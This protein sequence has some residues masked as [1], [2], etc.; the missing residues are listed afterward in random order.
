M[1]SFSVILFAAAAASVRVSM[2]QW[3][4]W[5]NFS[6]VRGSPGLRVSDMFVCLSLLGAA[7]A[8]VDCIVLCCS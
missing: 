2:S 4:L 1:R 7:R 5:F 8:A 3:V 6:R